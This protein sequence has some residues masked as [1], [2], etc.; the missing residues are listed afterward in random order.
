MSG[1]YTKHMGRV[2]LF[3]D[4]NYFYNV[5]NFYKFQ[6]HRKKRLSI[7]G[8]LNFVRAEVADR[9]SLETSSCQIVE[10]H[11]FRG[12][13]S[14][15]SAEEAS[16]LKDDRVFDDVLTKAGVVQHYTLLDEGGAVVHEKGIDVWLALEA[17]DLAVHA[18]YDVLC[19]IAGDGDYV[20]LLRKLNG[21][22]QRV[23]LLA[24]DLTYPQNGDTSS[25]RRQRDIRTS[26]Q[27]I[28]VCS[29]PIMMS[30]LIEDRTKKDNVLI[31]GL[32]Y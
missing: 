30:N 8:L 3:I 7:A 12:R 27:L 31:N 22:G 10:A 13:Y 32:F 6:H 18:R 14:A 26:A 15:Y 17:Y 4:G 1:P 11:Y 23:V 24:W 28:E 29:D 20:P 25:S 16:K 2:A 21:L 19:L 9:L 5:S